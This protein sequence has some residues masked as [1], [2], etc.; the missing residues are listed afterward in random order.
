MK[1][2][3]AAAAKRWNSIHTVRVP[4]S[5]WMPLRGGA[6]GDRRPLGWTRVGAGMLPA[7]QLAVTGNLAALR[8]ESPAGR[9]VPSRGAPGLSRR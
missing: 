5:S 4:G 6:I 7:G 9:L 2:R 8:G 1:V 3:M